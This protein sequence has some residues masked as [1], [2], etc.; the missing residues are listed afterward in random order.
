MGLDDS[1]FPESSALPPMEIRPATPEDAAAI[2]ETSAASCKAAYADIE[3]SH[4]L[5][6]MVDDPSRIEQIEEWLREIDD[7]EAVVYLVAERESIVGFCQVLCDERTPEHVEEGDAYLKSLYVHPDWWRDGIGTTLL[8]RVTEKIPDDTRRL[9]LSVLSENDRG[10]KFYERRGFERTGTGAFEA[11][12]TTY[13]TDRYAK[14]ID[15][16]ESS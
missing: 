8:D 7:D 1:F 4:D 5:L 15:A 14:P 3:N 2:H 16:D 9:T 10:K 13:P 12:S 11:G 6:A